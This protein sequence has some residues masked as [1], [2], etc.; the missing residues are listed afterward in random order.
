MPVFFDISR[1]LRG[2]YFDRVWGTNPAETPQM[3]PPKINFLNGSR[4]GASVF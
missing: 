1:Y 4:Y 3:D 2:K